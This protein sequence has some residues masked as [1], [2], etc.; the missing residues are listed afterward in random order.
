MIHHD[1]NQRFTETGTTPAGFI[2]WAASLGV[3]VSHS[4]VSRHRAG[5]QG[6]TAPWAL[7]YA[8]FFQDVK[9][10]EKKLEKNLKNT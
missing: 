4:T 7:A 8:C 2:A 5:T 1:L 10:F 6:I 9:T 3:T